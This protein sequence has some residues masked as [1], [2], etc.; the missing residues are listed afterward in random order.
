M[1]GNIVSMSGVRG[2]AKGALLLAVLF[3]AVGCARVPLARRGEDEK[4]KLAKAQPHT[5]LLYL[6]RDESFGGA[7]LMTIELNGTRVGE[8][9]PDT[10]FLFELHPGEHVITAYNKFNDRSTLVVNTHPGATHY[11]WQETKWGALLARPFLQEVEADK[12]AE[13]IK[14]CQLVRAFYM[15]E[16]QKPRV[17]SGIIQARARSTA[18]PR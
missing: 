17:P 8:T 13:A 2:A 3:H 9:A 18:E 4:A 5:S 6:Y 10:Y 14:E 16:D 11:I 1:M 12:G 15:P 7:I